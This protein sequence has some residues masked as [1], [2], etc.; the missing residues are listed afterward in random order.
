[1]YF[2]DFEDGRTDTVC[3]RFDNDSA[4][5]QEARLRALLNGSAHQLPEHRGSTRIIVLNEEGDEIH[6]VMM[7]R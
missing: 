4:A 5:I 7:K 1:M 6:S 3:A 2:F